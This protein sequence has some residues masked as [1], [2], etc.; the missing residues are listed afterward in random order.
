M[1]SRTFLDLFLFIVISVLLCSCKYQPST[2]S[3]ARFSCPR[4]VFFYVKKQTINFQV[5]ILSSLE[6]VILLCEQELSDPKGLFLR[7]V[8]T[9]ICKSNSKGLLTL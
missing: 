8:F 6:T 4:N 5:C 2:L 3:S 9:Q 7:L 1:V